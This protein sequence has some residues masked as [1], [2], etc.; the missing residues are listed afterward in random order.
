[1][2]DTALRSFDITFE[3]N[4][5]VFQAGQIVKGQVELELD[6]DMKMRL[7]EAGIQVILKG[8]A[9]CKWNE[10]VSRNESVT[11]FSRE[12]YFQD[13]KILW[14]PSQEKNNYNPVL[15]A[16]KYSFPFQYQLPSSGLPTSFESEY[17]RVRYS[18][19]AIIDQPRGKPD[20][21]FKRVFTV[22]DMYDLNEDPNAMTPSTAKGSKTIGMLMFTSD[23]IEVD[24]K[25]DRGAYCPGEVVRLS[26]TITNGSGTDIRHTTVQLIQMATCVG[27]GQRMCFENQTR[28]K[29]E[30]KTLSEVKTMAG[31][32]AKSS[33]D[34]SGA[35]IALPIPAVPP[36]VKRYCGIVGVEYM[37]K[38]IVNIPGL[39]KNLE[40]EL[41]ITIGVIPLRTYYPQ[42]PSFPQHPVDQ[43]PQYAEGPPPPYYAVATPAKIEKDQADRGAECLGP[44][45]YV[46]K[47]A[48]YD[49]NGKQP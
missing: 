21:K 31:C 12:H 42:S 48:Y 44:K 29:Y 28:T 25:T 15:P 27:S 6:Q 46:P 26:G 49:W 16:G 10:N 40:V 32:K 11:F 20:K 39:H 38:F 36:S 7:V 45:E 23:P 18:V 35:G 24:V 47:Y 17:G 22:L 5:D 41:P 4:M 43:P 33:A 37:I 3:N 13:A 8:E 9:W 34:L 1:M 2:P 30:S 14:A 19:E